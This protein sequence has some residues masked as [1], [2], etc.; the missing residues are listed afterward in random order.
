MMH[1]LRA[2]GVIDRSEK[3]QMLTMM[4]HGL[5]LKDELVQ[6]YTEEL[7]KESWEPVSDEEL[8]AL[9]QGLAPNSLATLVK[10]AYTMASADGELAEA[11]LAL[12]QRFLRVVGIPEE[13]LSKIDQWARVTLEV[14]RKGAIL[15]QPALEESPA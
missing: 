7:D 8:K 2:D 14:A 12:V 13:R 5:Q 9:G 1:V 6:R 4:V 15:F 11:E 3:Q 10:D